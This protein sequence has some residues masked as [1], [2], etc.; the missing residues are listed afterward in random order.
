MVFK[1]QSPDFIPVTEF[2]YFTCS[3]GVFNYDLTSLNFGFGLLFISEIGYKKGVIVSNN[4][5][6]GGAGKARK[7]PHVYEVRNEDAVNSGIGEFFSKKHFD[8]LATTTAA[9]KPRR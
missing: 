3:F 6:P 4:T 9:L 1:A 2:F 8:A 7:I 5:V